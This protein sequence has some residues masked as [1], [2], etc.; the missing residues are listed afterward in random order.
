[1]IQGN[2]E[3]FF[4]SYIHICVCARVFNGSC[5]QWYLIF[6]TTWILKIN[7]LNNLKLY[8]V[9]NTFSTP[10]FIKFKFNKSKISSILNLFW[11]KSIHNCWLPFEKRNSPTVAL[12]LQYRK[13]MIIEKNISYCQK[14]QLKKDYV[15]F[16]SS[17]H[18]FVIH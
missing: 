5:E 16:F 1:M 3:D 17:I 11:N 2:D 10:L 9:E 14:L 6:S 7:N 15:R 13:T 18:S 12:S 4:N 8:F